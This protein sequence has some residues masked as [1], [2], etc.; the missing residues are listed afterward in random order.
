MIT[1]SFDSFIGNS[2]IYDPTSGTW[3]LAASL[4]VARDSHKATL[5]ADGS[6]FIAG[7]VNE[8]FSAV[9]TTELYLGDAITWAPSGKMNVPRTVR[10]AV[11]L[12]DGEVLVAGGFIWTRL[13]GMGRKSRSH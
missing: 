8:S 2:E 11:L 6:V 7:G 12:A 13:P 5:L 9:R 3:T 4:N 1:G 10:E